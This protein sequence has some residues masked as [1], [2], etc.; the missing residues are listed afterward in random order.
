MTSCRRR[1]PDL[2]GAHGRDIAFD[3]TGPSPKADFA[4]IDARSRLLAQLRL[5]LDHAHA[6]PAAARRRLD[7]QG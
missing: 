5:A 6:T 4:S 2:D 1:T 3:M 7:Q